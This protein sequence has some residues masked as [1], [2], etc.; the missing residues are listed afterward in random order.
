MPAALR[1]AV[2]P[3]TPSC[4]VVVLDLAVEADEALLALPA[5]PLTRV[6]L[7]LMK[8]ARGA[9]GVLARL[10]AL[11][12]LLTPLA[13]DEAGRAGIRALV[14]YTHTVTGEEPTAQFF[15]SVRRTAGPA[16]GEVFVTAYEKIRE[17]GRVEGRVE[18]ARAILERQLR[19][20]FGALPSDAQ[21]RLR[22]AALEE[23][24]R[25]AERFA[26]ASTLAEVF[27]P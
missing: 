20:R 5:P 4:E 18:E 21:E 12:P 9:G 23:L 17:R 24:E 22:G 16:V 13:Q 26:L 8:A 2:E 11:A 7:V 3:F 6:T 1:P 14:V 25:W 19:A 10:E 15:E 27:G